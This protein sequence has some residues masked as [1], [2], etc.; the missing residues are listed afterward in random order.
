MTRTKKTLK[1]KTFIKVE[2][3]VGEDGDWLIK[4]SSECYEDWP[5]D[6]MSCEE[7]CFCKDSLP[8]DSPFYF[9]LISNRYDQY[10]GSASYNPNRGFYDVTLQGT[11]KTNQRLVLGPWF[12]TTIPEYDFGEDN[13]VLTSDGV[14]EIQ[15]GSLLGNID[16]EL[17]PIQPNDL[18][19]MISK[20]KAKNSPSYQQIRLSNSKSRPSRAPIGTL[21]YNS[22][23]DQL[24]FRGKNGWVKINTEELK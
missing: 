24:E 22:K 20:G 16:G 9:Q 19:S 4:E 18:L 17:S 2:V 3:E 12:P 6:I 21:V 15:K 13:L 7:G 10:Y 1:A 5:I 14:I 23:T 11:P 8:V